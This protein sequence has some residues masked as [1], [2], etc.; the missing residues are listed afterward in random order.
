LE[1]DSERREALFDAMSSPELRDEYKDWG[2]VVGY[3]A[4]RRFVNRET[5]YFSHLLRRN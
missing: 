4:H 3:R 5:L 1:R 2:G